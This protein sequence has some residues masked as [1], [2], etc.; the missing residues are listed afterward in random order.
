MTEYYG[1]VVVTVPGNHF[2]TKGRDGWEFSKETN[3]Y[4]HTKDVKE[5]LKLKIAL[6]LLTVQEAT[7]LGAIGHEGKVLRFSGERDVLTIG[8]DTPTLIIEPGP[9]K[10]PIRW[11]AGGL[12]S[13]QMKKLLT[14]CDVD[15][16]NF[17]AKFVN[18]NVLISKS[19]HFD[20]TPVNYIMGICT[21]HNPTY[22]RVKQLLEY[23]YSKLLES[24][25]ESE[26]EDLKTF[27][28]TLDYN[29]KDGCRGEELIKNINHRIKAP[30]IVQSV[31]KIVASTS[32][33]KG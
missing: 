25:S 23:K 14:Q 29:F 17:I 19:Y 10:Y 20:R 21:S 8:P 6:D 1:Y 24:L 13:E 30:S 28:L 33:F 11:A 5:Y 18:M 12:E 22:S 9:V 2:L 27:L 26:L 7:L 31:K 3:L 15:E 32:H 4:L 16:L